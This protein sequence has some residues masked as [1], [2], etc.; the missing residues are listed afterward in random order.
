MNTTATTATAHNTLGTY[1]LS[2]A[3]EV[4]ELAAAERQACVWAQPIRSQAWGL[5][6]DL[7]EALRA[8]AALG[9]AW[10]A[11]NNRR[12]ELA[13]KVAQRVTEEAMG[14]IAGWEGDED[15]HPDDRPEGLDDLA[16][17]G[18]VIDWTARTIRAWAAVHG[19]AEEGAWVEM[20]TGF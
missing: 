16:R 9:E 19:L 15:A 2:T 11:W 13:T 6:S 7:A 12:I 8:G 20:I 18:V 14:E 3:T 1:S 17:D 10:E 5:T 4:A